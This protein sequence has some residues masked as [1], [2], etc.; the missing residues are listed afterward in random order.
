MLILVVANATTGHTALLFSDAESLQ[1]SCA[2]FTATI[3]RDLCTEILGFADEGADLF[4]AGYATR[5]EFVEGRDTAR[6]KGEGNHI[7]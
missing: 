1:S 7:L 6:D 2:N 3:K 5:S 4:V